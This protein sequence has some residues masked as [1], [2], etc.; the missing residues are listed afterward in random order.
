MENGRLY[1]KS[2]SLLV[3]RITF[4]YYYQYVLEENADL[5]RALKFMETLQREFPELFSKE[6]ENFFAHYRTLFVQDLRLTV[7]SPEPVKGSTED[8]LFGISKVD[9]YYEEERYQELKKK[10]SQGSCGHPGTCPAQHLPET[11]HRRHSWI[12]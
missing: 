11:N 1:D 9:R 7:E 5:K 3:A 10:P 8:K 2:P 4:E 12:E 6:P